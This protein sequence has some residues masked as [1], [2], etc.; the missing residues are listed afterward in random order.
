MDNYSFIP[1]VLQTKACASLEAEIAKE[2]NINDPEK[3]IAQLLQ[4][5]N[6]EKTNQNTEKKDQISQES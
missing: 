3:T 6:E 2:L 1:S 5:H 4:E